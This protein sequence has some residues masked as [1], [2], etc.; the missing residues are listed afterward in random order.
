MKKILTFIILK[1]D[2]FQLWF[3]CVLRIST[4]EIIMGIIKINVNNLENYIIFQ[5]IDKIDKGIV[6]NLAS[7]PCMLGH[8]KLP[9]SPFW[10]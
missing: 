4:T 5:I 6:V 10:G 3:L 9:F 2:S 8:L 1:T 7:P